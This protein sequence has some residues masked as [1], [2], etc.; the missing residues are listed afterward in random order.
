MYGYLYFESVLLFVPPT[1]YYV[2]CVSITCQLLY[3]V[4]LCQLNILAYPSCTLLRHQYVI[5]VLIVG[6]PMKGIGDAI[7]K[8]NINI[9]NIFSFIDLQKY[10]KIYQRSYSSFSSTTL[11][12]KQ[13]KV[14]NPYNIFRWFLL[15]YF[16]VI[17]FS[18]KFETKRSCVMN[19]ST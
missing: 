7:P 2:F 13:M 18:V 3:F 5:V 4:S 19:I 1:F 14:L 10:T 12:Q 16:D 8:A 9:E 17:K 6:F 11:I 15:T